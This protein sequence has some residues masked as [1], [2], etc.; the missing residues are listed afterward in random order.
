MVAYPYILL[1][2]GVVIVIIG[3]LLAGLSAASPSRQPP[4][5]ARMKNAEIIKQ[6]Q[7]QQ[8]I[9]FPVLMVCFGLL[10]V[11]VS[12]VWRFAGRFL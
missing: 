4:I 11:A 8:R 1:A 2:V 10:C 3:I 5:S 12:L 9:P 6:L 7:Q